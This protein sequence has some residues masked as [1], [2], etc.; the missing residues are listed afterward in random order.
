MTTSLIYVTS[1][2]DTA[3]L[4]AWRHYGKLDGRVTEQLLEANRGLADHGPILPAGLRV[5]LPVIAPAP[6][7]DGVKLW[8]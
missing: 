7:T 2:G 4:I 3:D 8:D 5:T 1:D 6:Q